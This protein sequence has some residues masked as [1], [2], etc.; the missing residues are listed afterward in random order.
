MK[1]EPLKDVI[2]N[3]L[4]KQEG[5]FITSSNLKCPICK[6]D[7]SNKIITKKTGLCMSC[8]IFQ[9]VSSYE[10]SAVEFLKKELKDLVIV[11]ANLQGKDVKI[12]TLKGA[13]KLIDKAFEDVT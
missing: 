2:N 8:F 1:K 6:K 9:I 10:K 7:V 12:V 5:F 4:E 3:W 13:L 11:T